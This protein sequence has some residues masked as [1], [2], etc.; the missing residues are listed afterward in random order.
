MSTEEVVPAVSREGFIMAIGQLD[1]GA[2]HDW[3]IGLSVIAAALQ[4]E[5]L[6]FAPRPRDRQP[7]TWSI[8]VPSHGLQID[9]DETSGD[10]SRGRVYR[11]CQLYCFIDKHCTPLQ[12]MYIVRSLLWEAEMPQEQFGS[13]TR[14]MVWAK[15]RTED[16]DN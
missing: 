8:I 4:S 2:R 7:G 14:R 6:Y 13:A 16:I 1:Q 15:G 12:L 3:Q 9:I 10:G 5:L 11:H